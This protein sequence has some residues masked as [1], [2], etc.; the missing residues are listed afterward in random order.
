[1]V[2]IVIIPQQSPPVSSPKWGWHRVGGT[3]KLL[4]QCEE[5]LGGFVAPNTLFY[6]L[7]WRHPFFLSFFLSFFRLFLPLLVSFPLFLISIRFS[8]LSLFWK[9]KRGLWDH[10]AV[11]LSFFLSVYPPD[12]CSEAYAII[13]LSVCVCIPPNFFSLL[14]LFWKIG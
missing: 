14:F 10:L 11:S 8:L 1:M 4:V 9:K 6:T 7:H 2:V 3:C 5:S 13:L 12:F